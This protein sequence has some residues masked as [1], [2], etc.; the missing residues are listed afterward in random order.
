VNSFR[1]CLEKNV[2][3][4]RKPNYRLEPGNLFRRGRPRAPVTKKLYLIPRI[5]NTTN[6]PILEKTR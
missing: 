2:Y 1:A 6:V 3:T 5:V 4:V